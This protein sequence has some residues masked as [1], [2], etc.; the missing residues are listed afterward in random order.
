MPRY[1]RR[2][3]QWRHA[4]AERVRRV[5][6][7]ASLALGLGWL[8]LACG[9]SPAGS[10]GP[11]VGVL[12]I[13]GVIDAISARYLSRAIGKATDD[14]A[15][16][17]VVELNTPG[18]RLD[19]TRDMVEDILAARIP[20]AVY[21]APSGGRAASAGTFITASANFAAMA[22]ATSIGAASPITAT[23]EDLPETLARKIN[24]D[25]KAFIRGI[26][27]KRGRNAEAL[28]DTVTKALAYSA[29]EAIDLGIV[30]LVANDMP[31]LLAQLNGRSAETAAGTVIL[32]TVD[33]DIREI[34]NT[35]LENFLAL[36]ADPNIA[37]ILLAIGGMALL[38]E[39]FSPGVFGPGVVGVLA[40]LLAFVAFGQL[41][42]NWVGVALILFAMV[43][44]YFEVQ[45]P[46]V[47]VFGIGGVVVF[48]AGAFLL[49]GDLFEPPQIPEPTVEVNRWLIG[50]ITTTAA[51]AMVALFFLTREGGGSTGYVSAADG[52][53]VGQRGVA[54]SALDP[55]GTVRVGDDEWTATVDPGDQVDEGSEVKVVGVYAGGLLKV[56]SAAPAASEGRGRGRSLLRQMWSG[57]MGR[58]NK[59]EV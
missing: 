55:S 41:P 18:G 33:L 51:L 27:E 50:S 46:G 56:S 26:A 2:P 28:E 45:A 23:G 47:S 37:F 4:Q 39:F 43:L 19:S 31:D 16:L 42:V 15:V 14:G 36:I 1:S 52:A 8:A 53:L 17:V 25:T 30:D 24:E 38:A 29:S 34:S 35:L 57:F 9:L 13:D 3:P 58:D 54:L 22:P 5:I 7:I 48:V 44:F 49:F 12:R 32:D 40:L 59:P 10:E 11:H 6:G 20:V 21:V